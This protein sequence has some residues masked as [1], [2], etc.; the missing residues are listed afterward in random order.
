MRACFLKFCSLPK[1]QFPALQRTGCRKISETSKNDNF[2]IMNG[3]NE[4]TFFMD[5]KSRETPKASKTEQKL[6]AIVISSIRNALFIVMPSFG[7]Y[8]KSIRYAFAL[9]D[10]IKQLYFLHRKIC[11]LK[12]PLCNLLSQYGNHAYDYKMCRPLEL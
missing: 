11:S 10:I 8:R 1:K 12:G 2:Q 9:L 3:R 6:G 5:I 4:K 7:S